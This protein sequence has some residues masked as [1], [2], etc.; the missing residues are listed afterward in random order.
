MKRLANKVALITGA[1]S[2]IGYASALRLAEEGAAIAGLD[3]GECDPQ[4]W[5]LIADTAPDCAF[6]T[7]DVS[8]DASISSDIA[9]AHD[10]FGRIDVL[11]TAAGVGVSSGAMTQDVSEDDWDLVMRVNLKGC[12]LSAKHVAPFMLQQQ[13]GSI[14]HIASV[15]GLEG[16]S[17][18]LSYGTSKG[19]LIQMT[20]V[21]AADFAR[22]GI[23]VNCVCPGAVET[24]MTA[25][26]QDPSLQKIRQQIEAMHLMNR[27]AEPREIANAILFLASDEASFI[28]GHP[29]VVDGGWTAGRQ[30]HV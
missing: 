15:E 19:G 30:I 10:H 23:R 2:G 25:I 4:A 29:L 5:Q 11:V 22:Q 16:V 12:F 28:T 3:L 13:S 6:F 20:R 7:A 14:I 27:F 26:L 21:M 1:A 17:G 18:Q 24:P 8:D 9:A